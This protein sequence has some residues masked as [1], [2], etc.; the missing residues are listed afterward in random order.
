M[1]E[2][3]LERSLRWSFCAKWH[4]ADDVT[5]ATSLEQEAIACAF[6]IS[7]M[8]LVVHS[9]VI[10]DKVLDVILCELRN[11]RTC[12]EGKETLTTCC[13]DIHIV[14]Q[15]WFIEAEFSVLK[16]LSAVGVK[17]NDLSL[18]LAFAVSLVGR[19]NI[20][21]EAIASFVFSQ[22]ELFVADS[23]REG[24]SKVFL[25]SL[26][27]GE[28]GRTNQD[29]K[30][31]LE[32]SE[33]MFN[34]GPVNSLRCTAD[35]PAAMSAKD[36]RFFLPVGATWLW[37]V[38]SSTITS[39]EEAYGDDRGVTNAAMIVL[40]AL[41]L[42]EQLETTFPCLLNQGTK[43]Y[44]LCNVCL[45]PEEVLRDD[46][47]TA[48]LNSL[49]NQL[50]GVDGVGVPDFTRECFQH[51]RLSR[52][53]KISDGDTSDPSFAPE[54][55]FL[56]DEMRA[57]DDFV[58][59]LCEVYIEYGGQYEIF[60]R[61]M[62]FFLRHDF[63]DKVVK[64]VLDR[65]QPIL[66]VL[67]IEGEARESLHLSLVQSMKGVLPSVDS[68]SRDSS[69]LLD[70]FAAVLK[71]AKKLV[72]GDYIYMLAISFLSRNLASSFQRCE[73]GL[74]AMKKRLS[75]V[76]AAIFYDIV[77]T[78]KQLLSEEVGTK[79][80]MVACVIDRCS[81]RSAD[82]QMQEDQ[83]QHQWSMSD[84]STWRLAI[85]VLGGNQR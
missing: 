51:S 43:L 45:Y 77:L 60:T 57:L 47:V 56:E 15:S 70:S 1:L 28:L 9:G 20:G 71:T 52:M 25:R 44:H 18:I 74:E 76:P 35:F 83:T 4:E 37:N 73:C 7:F 75:G 2:Y 62:R 30:T 53:K 24:E 58:G 42:L 59:D 64:S 48:C 84:E 12:W 80:E 85:D 82:L 55:L 67:T 63:P 50:H 23:N 14:R 39:D 17:E 3:C 16:C 61:F 32:H 31:Q 22:N 21:H 27:L 78:S 19:L 65:L 26:F 40:D 46:N 10:A 69:V 41:S 66:N 72:R 36:D 11:V 13:H 68:S 33:R 49:F 5:A 8:D 81:D 6:V 54:R 34:G 79:E 38:L 29:R